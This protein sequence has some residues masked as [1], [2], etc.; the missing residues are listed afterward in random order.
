MTRSIKGILFDLGDTLLDFGQVDIPSLFEAGARLAYD[1]LQVLG[2][3]LPPLARYHRRQLW[4]IRW[5]YLKSRI[6]RRE[7]NSLDLIGR[8][9]VDMGHDLT[10]EQKDDLAWKWYEPLSKCATAEA[11]LH[12]TLKSIGDSGL[13]LG[14]ISNTFIPAVVL[15]R[16]LRREG[17]LEF[18]PV[19]VYSCDVRFRK[20]HPAIFQ[21]ALDRL[22]TVAA[23]TIFVGDSPKA[24]IA[25]ANRV[26]MISV[27]KDPRALHAKS[28]IQPRHTIRKL[29][30]LPELVLTQYR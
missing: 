24:D 14:L 7:F 16:H 27:L 20:P 5:S 19:R 17:L 25:G 15:D 2:K 3:P 30:E 18:L 29:G 4:A 21:A 12:Q 28:P 1:Y 22:G 11:G 13:K 10:P 9:S 8:L 26:G 6:T 23:E